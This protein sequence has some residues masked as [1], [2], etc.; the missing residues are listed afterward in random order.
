MAKTAFIFPGQGSQF[1]GMGR[2]LYESHDTAKTVFDKAN[3]IL[4]FS[5]TDIMFGSGGSEEQETAT[6]KKTEFTQPALFTHSA[7][8]MAVLRAAD[9]LP[10]MTAGHSLGEYSALYAAGAI[11]FADALKTVHRRGQLMGAA[12]NERPG[13]MAAILGLGDDQVETLCEQASTADH[14][15]V[16]AN[17]NSVGQ[18]VISGDTVAVERAVEM[19]S[20][21]GARRAL[22]LPVSGAFHS[23]LMEHAREGLETALESLPITEPFCPV[24]LNVS[25]RASSDPSEIR[26]RLGEQLISPVR[27]AQTLVAMDADGATTFIEVGTGKVLSGLVKRTLGREA[28]TAQ[29]GTESNL[30]PLIQPST[31]TEA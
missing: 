4:G 22:L 10:D 28:A 17:Y 26:R 7:A 23:P 2:D 3:E 18:I 25:A 31:I 16:A 29:A 1:V 8:A 5:L 15:V 14:V 13:T 19:A 12:G 11:G 27:W 9:V 30:M 21:A 6:L 24:Y 20:E